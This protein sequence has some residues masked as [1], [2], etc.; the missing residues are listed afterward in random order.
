MR[1]LIRVMIVF[2]L[3]LVALSALRGFFSPSIPRKTT[4]TSGHGPSQ[5]GKLVKDP[6]CGT[7]VTQDQSIR[8][9]RGSEVFH[10]CSEDCR[11]KFLATGTET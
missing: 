9:S 8:T 5:S 10:F 3:V 6:I 1:F 2:G 4:P 11:D 7:Y